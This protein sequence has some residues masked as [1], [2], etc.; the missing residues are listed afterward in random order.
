MMKNIFIAAILL[1]MFIVVNAQPL[2]RCYSDEIREKHI[3]NNTELKGNLNTVE[4]LVIA[5]LSENSRQHQKSRSII[6]IPVVVHVIHDGDAVGDDENISDTQ[7][8]SQ[9]EVLN[10][11]F[12]K[13]NADTANTPNIYK[14]LAADINIEF[15][16]AQRNPNGNATNGI[17]RHNFNQ[18]S[19]DD[20][21]ID[22]NIKPQTTWDRDSYLNIWT[23]RLGGN[24]S[25]VL[26][27]STQPGFPADVDGVVVGY[28]FFGNTGNVQ[29]PYNKGRTTTHEVGHW[30]GLL[31]TWGTFGGCNDDD[32]IS[33]TPESSDPYYG[34]P[35]FPQNSCNTSNMFMN[36]MDYTNDACMNLFTIGQKTRMSAIINSVRQSILTSNGCVAVPVNNVDVS[37]KQIVYP[38]GNVCENPLQPIIEV[39][40]IGLET[41]TSFSVLYQANG[42]NLLSF[43]WN[44]DLSYRETIYITLPSINFS[45]GINDLFISISSPN[46]LNDENTTNNELSYSFNVSNIIQ[47]SLA[48]PFEEGFEDNLFPPDNFT[49]QNFDGD[50]TWQKSNYGAYG[51][52]NNGFY[53]DNFSGT[54]GNNPRGNIDALVT[55]PFNLFG[56]NPKLQFDIA[57]ARRSNNSKDS[58]I[59]SAS[60]DCG[61]TWQRIFANGGSGLATSSNTNLAFTP[62]DSSWKTQIIN[63]SNYATSASVKFK[64]ENKSDWGNNLYLDNINLSL[65]PLSVKNS[66]ND[67]LIDIYPNPA[68]NYFVLNIKTKLTSSLKIQVIDILG[69][70]L[71]TEYAHNYSDKYIISTNNWNKGLYSVKV[72]HENFISNKK[73]LVE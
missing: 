64:F 39:E 62:I 18:N 26:G 3:A 34:C 27:Y 32:N 36:Y 5:Y 1:L 28:R 16:M 35:S 30:L 49:L 37:L 71:Y 13:L 6:T 66:K 11:D 8:F 41:I 56:L 47:N 17:T 14:S 73:I 43:S 54:S 69:K 63:L 72:E 22:N 48:V 38:N 51:T 12:R 7:I 15:C 10:K 20:N 33:D 21:F 42:G 61:N 19:V 4:Q 25:N 24:I 67:F 60:I 50:V 59:I 9:I 45:T 23:V 2:V 46:N 44:G 52:S 40:N 31:H 68:K 29:S 57:Y 65:Q 58:L 55:S 53:I 70:I